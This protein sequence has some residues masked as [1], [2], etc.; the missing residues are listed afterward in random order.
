MPEGLPTQP[1]RTVRVINSLPHQ[2]LLLFRHTAKED[3]HDLRKVRHFAS[4]GPGSMPINMD[5]FLW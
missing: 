3:H 1:E 5:H 2:H 4:Y